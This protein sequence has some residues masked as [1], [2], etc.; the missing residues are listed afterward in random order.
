M[1]CGLYM[2]ADTNVSII[3]GRVWND[4]VIGYFRPILCIIQHGERARADDYTIYMINWTFFSDGLTV[5]SDHI[6][7]GFTV[8]GSGPRE[9]VGA[10]FDKA[11]RK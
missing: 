3:A 11:C 8:M 4:E 6:V 1:Y 10:K 2:N 7:S 5:S 9:L